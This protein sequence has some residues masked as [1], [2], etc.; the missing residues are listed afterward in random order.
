MYGT[1]GA[2]D[3]DDDDTRV[4]CP[5]CKL[6]YSCRCPKETTACTNLPGVY[7]ELPLSTEPKTTDNPKLHAEANV[8]VGES[9]ALQVLP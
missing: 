3:W 9:A 2:F 4:P 7:I 6:T 1:Y 5:T 8:P